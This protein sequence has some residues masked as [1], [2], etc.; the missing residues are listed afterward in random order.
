MVQ[1]NKAGIQRI[2]DTLL[3]DNT[4][5]DI[6]ASDVRTVL[7]DMNDSLTFLSS[8]AVEPAIRSFSIEGQASR[9]DAGTTLSGTKTFVFN[10]SEEDNVQGNLT[11]TQTNPGQAAQTLSSS[12]DPKTSSLSQ[13]INNVTLAA[14]ETVTF[15]LSGV[16]DLAGNA[17]FD[18]TFTV[19]GRTD[20]EY[21]YI[22]DE[23]DNDP[24]DVVVANA[25]RSAFV[26]GQQDLV[27]PTFSGTRYLTILQKASEP[28]LTQIVIDSVDQI[29][30]FTK[31]DD[32][33]TINS[34]QFDAY[35]SNNLLV[36]SVVSGDAVTI[37]R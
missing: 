4:A 12:I 19:T 25:T 37:V 23:A 20:D 6:S 15:T 3:A 28:E 30:A 13:A 32:A 34:Q 29:G 8:S 27:V 22:S 31:T 17:T 16:S 2:I 33:L 24:S 7:T 10:L 9:V 5:G 11:L 14:G 21:V 36:G 18:R 35:V 1:M 26:A